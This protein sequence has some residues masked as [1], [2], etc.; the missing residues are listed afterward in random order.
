MQEDEKH[1]I[2]TMLV[3]LNLIRCR[4]LRLVITCKKRKILIV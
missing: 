1:N 2:I 4:L 3:I